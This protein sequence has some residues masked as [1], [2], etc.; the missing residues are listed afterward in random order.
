MALAIGRPRRLPA[1]YVLVAGPRS[2]TGSP[3]ILAYRSNWVQKSSGRHGCSAAASACSHGRLI[4]AAR[5]FS[6]WCCSTS[7]GLGGH[8]G[9]LPRCFVPNLVPSS[10]QVRALIALA[11]RAGDAGLLA[12]VVECRLFGKPRG[13]CWPLRAL[14]LVLANILSTSSVSQSPVVCPPSS[15]PGNSL[16]LAVSRALPDRPSPSTASRP[17]RTHPLTDPVAHHG[18]ATIVLS[19]PLGTGGRSVATCSPVCRPAPRGPAGAGLRHDRRSPVQVACTP[20]FP[21]ASVRMLG[22]SGDELIDNSTTPSTGTTLVPPRGRRF[23]RPSPHLA[24]LNCS[25]GS[26]AARGG[27]AQRS[28]R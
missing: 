26:A 2:G 19:P 3:A 24:M 9:A 5:S 17:A 27:P 1:V 14:A 8:S 16:A 25:S 6:P 13:T 28:S 15:P 4:D 20:A 23:G 22:G 10:P 11:R 21:D 12:V 7:F 18:S